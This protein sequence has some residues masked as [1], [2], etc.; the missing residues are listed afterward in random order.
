MNPFKR[1]SKDIYRK[2]VKDLNFNQEN[3]NFRNPNPEEYMENLFGITEKKKF[4]PDSPNFSVVGV[5]GDCTDIPY[6]TTKSILNSMACQEKPKVL[7]EAIEDSDSL[8]LVFEIPKKP[9]AFTFDFDT[10]DISVY[11]GQKKMSFNSGFKI[12]PESVDSVEQDFNN[13]IYT[14]N[15]NKKKELRYLSRHIRKYFVHYPQHYA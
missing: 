13:G 11:A 1:K 15:I 14:I 3:A 9:D 10:G 12:N 7:F 2:I 5:F 6:A 4:D 8:M